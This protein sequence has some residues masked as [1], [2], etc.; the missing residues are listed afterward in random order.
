MRFLVFQL[1]GPMASWGEPATGESR[2]SATHPTR[3]AILGLV[4][5]ALGVRRSAEQEL[6]ALRDGIDVAV[7]QASG[8]L[9]LQDYHTAQVPGQSRHGR[10]FTRRDELA[11]PK[12]R[13]HTVLSTREY[14]CDGYWKVAL[15]C[16]ESC[17]WTL[18]TI[19]RALE[20][21][22]HQLFLGRKGCPPAAPLAPRVV[23]ASG[24]KAALSEHFAQLTSLA[25]EVERH[26]LGIGGS[27]EYTWEGEGGDIEP[28][29]TRYPHDQPLSRVRWQ[30]GSRAEHWCRVR[31][32]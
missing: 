31:E 8:G 4:A 28:Q 10:W 21:P 18:E 32:G 5:S 27:A 20:K 14:R 12:D 16:L 15:R 3:S 6:G 1:Y 7:K 30:F 24:V 13:L 26:L 17:P 22:V 29:Q 9:L 2:R 19:A 25:P 11:G 23:E